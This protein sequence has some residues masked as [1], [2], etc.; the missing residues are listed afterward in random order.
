MTR[1]ARA[2]RSCMWA[3]PFS[4]SCAIV[5]TCH[6][7]DVACDSTSKQIFSTSLGLNDTSLSSM[8]CRSTSMKTSMLPSFTRAH[9]RSSARLRI[10]M[11]ASCT[12]C[13]MTFLCLFTAFGS[14]ATTLIRVSRATYFMLLSLW[15]KNFPRMFTASTLSPP[16]LSISMMVRAHSY[17]TAQ[18][19]FLDPSVFEATCASTS[20]I[21]S[22]ISG[23]FLPSSRSRCRIWTCRKGSGTPLTWWSLLPKPEVVRC[24]SILMRLWTFLRNH[25]MG[26]PV[27][28]SLQSSSASVTAPSST[29]CDR[30]SSSARASSL[31]SSASSGAFCTSRTAQ[32]ADFFFR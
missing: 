30:S 5:S 1:K 11:S 9:A 26:S 13:T 22:D 14:I 32:M 15:P 6:C 28:S 25:W 24:L 27:G 17:S 4:S 16:V 12:H 21:R 19:A 29:P 7:G 31:K 18:P 8:N 23:D 2:D 3:P 20:L 10:E